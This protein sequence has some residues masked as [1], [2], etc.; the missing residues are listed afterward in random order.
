MS[1]GQMTESI[2]KSKFDEMEHFST[3]FIKYNHHLLN[4]ELNIKDIFNH[5]FLTK[6]L[7]FNST[8]LMTNAKSIDE[9]E[10][11]A[12]HIRK[13]DESNLIVKTLHLL[14]E[15]RV[16]EP[17][18][19]RVFEKARQELY[20]ICNKQQKGDFWPKEFAK[21][22]SRANMWMELLMIGVKVTNGFINKFNHE[23]LK[24]ILHNYINIKYD[25]SEYDE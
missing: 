25:I 3:Q 1:N 19:P 18:K 9:F 16:T 11:L 2:D 15:S 20:N 22:L 6:P 4:E 14:C 5:D 12:V 7:Q 10:K 8:V 13:R 24:E 23:K 21:E 17:N